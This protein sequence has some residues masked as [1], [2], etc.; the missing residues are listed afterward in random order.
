M[1]NSFTGLAQKNRRTV[2]AGNQPDSFL[3]LTDTHPSNAIPAANMR[4]VSGSG[5]GVMPIKL[6]LSPASR[7]RPHNA[8]VS[9][10]TATRT[11]SSDCNVFFN[12]QS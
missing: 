10:E 12:E 9:K 6:M 11:R 4:E 7:G 5:M 1:L 2:C 3:R 8:R